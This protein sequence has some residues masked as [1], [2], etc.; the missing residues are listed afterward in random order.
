MKRNIREIEDNVYKEFIQDLLDNHPNLESKNQFEPADDL[1]FDK[2]YKHKYLR[3]QNAIR[4]SRPSS[5]PI[6]ENGI[7]NKKLKVE[8]KLRKAINIIIR[9]E[10]NELGPKS[11]EYAASHLGKDVM[12]DIAK[13]ILTTSDY[14]QIYDELVY[15]VGLD[16]KVADEVVNLLARRSKDISLTEKK[17]PKKKEPIDIDLDLDTPEGDEELN[18]DTT[19]TDDIPDMGMDTGDMGMGGSGDEKEIGNHLQAALEAA[20]RMPDSETKSK[21]IRQIGNTALFF[22]KT[23]IPTGDQG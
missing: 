19:P 13:G 3:L 5:S 7:Y 16:P 4:L 9:E 20:K 2:T 10:L 11:M 15:E 23:Q 6:R 17:K 22:L 18:L 12:H 1:S 21:L 8:N 14:D